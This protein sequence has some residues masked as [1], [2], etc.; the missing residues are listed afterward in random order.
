MTAHGP[1][2]SIRVALWTRLFINLRCKYGD[3]DALALN[4]SDKKLL[5]ITALFHDSGREGD[6]EDIW[7][8]ESSIKCYEYLTKEHSVDDSRA[9]LF[10][11]VILNKDTDKR[12]IL[13]DILHDA[14]CLDIMRCRKNFRIHELRVLKQFPQHYREIATIVDQAHNVICN[15]KPIQGL[16]KELIQ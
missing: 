13:T 6:G 16:L 8:E 10:A 2:H 15:G 5:Q 1:S 9:Q 3:E 7:E 4:D 11:D 14:D 12:D